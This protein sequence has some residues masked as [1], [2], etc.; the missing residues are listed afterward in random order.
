MKVLRENFDKTIA[1]FCKANHCEHLFNEIKNLV[2]SEDVAVFHC[3]ENENALFNWKLREELN[4]IN[5]E[6][7][8]KGLPI[9]EVKSNFY[10]DRIKEKYNEIQ[11]KNSEWQKFMRLA[12]TECLLGD[13]SDE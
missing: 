2:L 13:C 5:H 4:I 6:R 3:V 9:F 11:L 1:D 10:R 12:V 8:S 7:Q